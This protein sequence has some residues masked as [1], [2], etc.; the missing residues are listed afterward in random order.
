MVKSQ[1]GAT[2]APCPA[3]GPSRPATVGNLA[4]ALRLGEQ[5]GGGAAVMLTAGP[6][7]GAFEEH[8]QRHLVAQRKL[9]ES[10]ALGVAA[11]PDTARERGEVL[12]AHH[13]R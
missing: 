1:T 12:G 6:E 5:V 13:H 9:G 7:S 4:G 2:S 3:D 11:R 10:I 8:H